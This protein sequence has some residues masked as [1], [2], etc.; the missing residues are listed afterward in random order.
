M[1]F[2]HELE[3]VS[4]NLWKHCRSDHCSILVNEGVFKIQYDVEN[5]HPL[6]IFIYIDGPKSNKG[7]RVVCEKLQLNLRYLLGNDSIVINTRTKLSTYIWIANKLS[8]D[9][10]CS[11]RGCWSRWHNVI[12]S[13]PYRLKDMG[14]WGNTRSRW[15]GAESFKM[16]N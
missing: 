9:W 12:P 8:R 1:S 16:F 4:R 14:I 5:I 13:S 15:I 7:A 6:N 10:F 3:T 2:Q 11:L